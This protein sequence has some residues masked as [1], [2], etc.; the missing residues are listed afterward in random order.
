MC[1][2]LQSILCETGCSE[3]R[4]EVIFNWGVSS[5]ADT[6]KPSGHDPKLCALLEEE[7]WTRWPPASFSTSISHWFCD[8]VNIWRLLPLRLLG[9]S[10]NRIVECCK[11]DCTMGACQTTSLF[12]CVWCFTQLLTVPSRAGD[13]V[14]P[15]VQSFSHFTIS[16]GAQGMEK[17]NSGTQDTQSKGL[18]CLA[19]LKRTLQR[20]LQ[21]IHS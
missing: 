1:Q 10:W 15:V 5:L 2:V 14:V 20:N 21:W 18:F 11:A 19:P 12:Q 3:A 7:G 9:L 13:E 4:N 17:Q 8:F 16:A 6:Q